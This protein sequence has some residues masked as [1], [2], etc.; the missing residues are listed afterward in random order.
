[1]LRRDRSAAPGLPFECSM[2][3]RSRKMPLSSPACRMRTNHSRNVSTVAPVMLSPTVRQGLAKKRTVWVSMCLLQGGHLDAFRHGVASLC[4]V[5][6]RWNA[7]ALR[8]ES[9][10]ADHKRLPGRISTSRSLFIDCLPHSKAAFRP[11]RY[12]L[13]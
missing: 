12:C 9:F 5:D 8:Q 10:V 3:G 13:A 1:V 4:K 7:T 6:C 11:C 2:S